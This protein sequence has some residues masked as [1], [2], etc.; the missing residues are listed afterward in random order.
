MG[1]WQLGFVI[2]MAAG[3]GLVLTA[4]LADR[5]RRRTRERELTAPPARPGIDPSLRPDYLSAAE[6]RRPVERPTP[7]DDDAPDAAPG[8][9]IPARPL[10][11]ARTVLRAPRVLVCAD[12][13]TTLREVMGALATYDPLVIAA[14][15]FH[16]DVRQ[17]LAANR[18]QALHDVVAVVADEA[19][20]G[21]LAE[22][23]DARPLE[24]RDLMAG[25]LPDASVGHATRFVADRR[26]CRVSG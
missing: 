2:T 18:A 8:A 11:D 19:A 1:G 7:P 14:P 16:D 6:V 20:R 26:E 12:E 10:V 24:R 9:P 3:F 23:T 5:T 13:V 21:R 4:V 17:T 25:W 22:L 15:G